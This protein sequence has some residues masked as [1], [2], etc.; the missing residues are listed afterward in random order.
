MPP[1]NSMRWPVTQWFLS[2]KSEAIAGPI[3][4]GVPPRR[5]AIEMK[6]M[7]V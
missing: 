1:D 2:D 4:S 3:S 6:G 7:P 5:D